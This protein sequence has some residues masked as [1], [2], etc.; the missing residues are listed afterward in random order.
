MQTNFSQLTTREL[1][2]SADRSDP[3]QK[4]LSERLAEYVVASRRLRDRL[5][6]LQ[7]DYGDSC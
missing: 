5:E 3:W 2:N 6:T 7:K 1:L 4:A